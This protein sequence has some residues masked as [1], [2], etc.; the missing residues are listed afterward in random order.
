MKHRVNI[1]IYYSLISIVC[2]FKKFQGS[3]FGGNTKIYHEI[4]LDRSKQGERFSLIQPR[5]SKSLR[6][7]RGIE[8]E[9]NIESSFGKIG[10][11][12][13]L[14]KN[15]ISLSDQVY[16]YEKLHSPYFLIV[17]TVNFFIQSSIC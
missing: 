6:N 3:S 11:G 14:L 13:I 1:S 4:F 16:F 17:L 2:F 10:S 15:Y 9:K 7:G 8:K 5:N 12:M